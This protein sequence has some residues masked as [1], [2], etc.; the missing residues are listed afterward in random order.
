MSQS[1]KPAPMP[2][3]DIRDLEERAFNAWPA[4]QTQ[5]FGGWVARTSRGYTKRA[6]SL[7]AW[8]P[9]LNIVEAVKLA[10]PLYAAQN[11]PL[12]VR[13]SPLATVETDAALATAKFTRAD[14]SIVMTASV[15][16][17][18][19]DAHVAITPKPTDAWLA[20]FATANH[21]KAHDRTTLADML[22]ALRHP[23]A[24][25]TATSDGASVGYGMAVVE[26]G[27]IGLY[28]IVTVDAARRQGI[29]WRVVSSL[30]AWGIRQ[31]ATSAYLQVA[32][33]NEP[34]TRM[35]RAQG[36]TEAYRYHYRISPTA[37]LAAVT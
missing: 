31:K 6:N 9:P 19:A 17:A 37:P 35:Y 24:F 18:A 5:L 15:A 27:M 29:G 28:D 2:L 16:H 7:N 12:V 3:A 13:L 1:T 23:A 11:L 33:A 32:A 21:V 22:A 26:R 20:G 4:L 8:A 14:E 30:M 34:A 10:E 25:A 36:F